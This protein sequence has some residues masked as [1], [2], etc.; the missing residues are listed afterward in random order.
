MEESSGLALYFLYNAYRFGNVLTFGQ[1]WKFSISFI[2]RGVV[3]L[4]VSPGEG[5]LWYCPCVLLSV[6]ALRKIKNRWLEAWTIIALAAASLLLHS[7]WSAWDGGWSWG[8]RLLLPV[9]PGLVALTGV[10]SNGWR[11]VLVAFAIVGFLLTAPNLI[12]FYS[13]YLSEA[14]EQG[15]TDADLMWRASRSPLLHQW[16]AAYRQVQDARQ[17]DVRQLLSQRSE[18]PA[19]TISS[20]RALRVVGVWWWVLPVVH[21]RRVW[22]ILVSSLLSVCGFFLLL[23]ARSRKSRVKDPDCISPTP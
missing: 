2:P 20:S 9:L 8:P 13:R 22:G 14:N 5:L 6:I 12:S 16:A 18:Q 3:G 10:L 15:V 11:K 4:L 7:L 21:I 19:G 23:S 1:P 17:Y